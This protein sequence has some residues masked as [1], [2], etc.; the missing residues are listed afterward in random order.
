MNLHRGPRGERRRLRRLAGQASIPGYSSLPSFPVRPGADPRSAFTLV[1][2]VVVIAIVAVLAALLLPALS[3]AKARSL[4][5]VCLSNLKQMTLAW[6]L[7][8]H[9]ENDRVAMNIG[10]Q[11]QEDWESWVRGCLTLDV[12]PPAWSSIPPTDSTDVT[13]LLR[14][15]MRPYGA[16]PGIWR[17][18]ADNST[19]TVNGVRLP[20]IRSISMNLHLG[21]YHPSRTVNGPPWVTEWMTKLMVKTTRDIRNPGPASCFVFLD[22]REDSIKDSH[23]LVHPGGFLQANP[24]QYRLVS[25]P[26]S[27]HNG[28][29][30][31]SFA[32]GHV[33][34]R[35]WL[36]SRTAPPL[37]RD[38][39]L[40]GTFEGV[41]CPGNPDVRWL[42][43]R[44]FQQD[45]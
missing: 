14:S 18:P 32:D 36:D 42:Q 13:Y 17:C 45:N 10:Y 43:E 41:S 31:L 9:G 8:A 16:V 33:E 24:A 30:S 29:G 11:A 28:A 37:V 4:G 1:E 20:R 40:V 7:Y 38:H 6:T 27:Y 39:D 15:P 22:D 44:T 2:L 21:T 34:S 5:I 25:Y 35:R 19:R 23:F 3:R 12:P 26:A